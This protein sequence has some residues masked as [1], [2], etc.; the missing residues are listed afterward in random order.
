MQSKP[1]S[2]TLH[3]GFVAYPQPKP[4]CLAAIVSA[5]TPPRL[6]ASAARSD[7]LVLVLTSP[8]RLH[9]GAHVVRVALHLLHRERLR[10]A[11]K[12]VVR[13]QEEHAC[14][15]SD[16]GDPG[17]ECA[18]SSADKKHRVLREWTLLSYEPHAT[19]ERVYCVSSKRHGL[20][21]GCSPRARTRL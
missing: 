1:Q 15:H 14:R 7:E 8:G 13:G 9:D 10:L 11:R 3:K 6:D 18:G 4:Q 20:A 12:L 19:P 5:L 2:S 16:A 17:M 21:S